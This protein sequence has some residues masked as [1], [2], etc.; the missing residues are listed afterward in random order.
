MRQLSAIACTWLA[1]DPNWDMFESSTGND[2]QQ[3]DCTADV[4]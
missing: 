4:S 1:P 3:A 2:A